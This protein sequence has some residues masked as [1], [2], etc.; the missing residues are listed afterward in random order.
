[1]NK[2]VEPARLELNAS[3]EMTARS[4]SL[5]SY[6]SSDAVEA[7]HLFSLNANKAIGNSHPSD[8]ERWL[9]FLIADHHASGSQD[10][11]FFKRW[12]V[13][14]EE[15]PPDVADELVYDWWKGRDVLEYYDKD[16]K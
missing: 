5:T 11:E 4:Q 15:W 16:K 7:L 8:Y 9:D 10:T 3:I 6:T 12:L 1:M 14:I 13:Q 2:V